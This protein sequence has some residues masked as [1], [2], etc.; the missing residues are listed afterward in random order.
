M[1]ASMTRVL[2]ASLL[3][4]CLLCCGKGSWREY[5]QN[6]RGYERQLVCEES[7]WDVVF[8]VSQDRRQA[9][10]GNLSGGKFRLI[11]LES[12]NV[13]RSM[14]MR[15]KS[16]QSVS[17]LSDGRR[18]VLGTDDG[19]VHLWDLEEGKEI[20]APKVHR[21]YVRAV[22]CSRKGDMAVSGG[23]EGF[24]VLWDPKEQMREIGK[25]AGRNPGIRRLTF[26]GSGKRVLSGHWDGAIRL[27]D[28][29]T[30]RQ[31]V[32]LNSSA[33]SDD[34]MS[35]ALSLDGR[36]AL[37]SYLGKQSV[38]YW[39]LEKGMVINRLEIGGHPTLANR[40]LHVASVA[41]SADGRK[42]LFG[43]AFGSVIYWDLATWR[44]IDHNRVHKARLEFVSFSEDE[45]SC[46]SVGCDANPEGS[47]M[48][49]IRWWP[50]PQ[51][52]L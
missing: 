22:A 33:Y 48:V 37:S 17:F 9:I 7:I 29:G 16:T 25:F 5:T 12:G 50:L 26:D 39:D 44:E 38:V 28:T 19:A 45:K 32:C 10:G 36:F 30:G 13:V 2:L 6:K 15:V 20:A 35:I 18:A 3:S 42:A 47:H 34:V 11:D 21:D 46:I 40:P 27:W 14:D 41:F 49:A 43:T 51:G 24:I 52:H 23:D 8:A 1:N 31:I 4:G